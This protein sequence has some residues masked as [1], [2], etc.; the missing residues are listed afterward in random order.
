VSSVVKV[1]TNFLSLLCALC[2]EMVRFPDPAII[3]VNP[4]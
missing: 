1:F 2:G 4:W 3:R